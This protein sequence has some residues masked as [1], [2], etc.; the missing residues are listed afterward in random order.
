[1]YSCTTISKDI[2]PPRSPGLTAPDYYLWEAMK[3]A[4]YKD[5][6]HTPLEPKKGIA[7]LHQ[8]HPSN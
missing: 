8:E 2:W 1:M 5:N 7:E 3:A 4:I 6:P